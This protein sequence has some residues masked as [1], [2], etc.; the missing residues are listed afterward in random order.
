[1]AHFFGSVQ[2]NRGEATRVGSQTS[3]V[4]AA[5]QGWNV[6]GRVVV[7]HENNEDVIYLFLTSGSNGLHPERLVGK[8][9]QSDLQVPA[10]ELI[11]ETALQAV[12]Q[13]LVDSFAGS[14]A[15]AITAPAQPRRQRRRPQDRTDRRRTGF[16]ED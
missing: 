3:G 9:T 6:G 16:R 2:G 4:R 14:P 5:A 15:A 13:H 10:N 12:R 1:M 11:R 7:R 8:F